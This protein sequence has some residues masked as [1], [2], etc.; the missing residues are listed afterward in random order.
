MLRDWDPDLVQ[1]LMQPDIMTIPARV[2]E[3]GI[4]RGEVTGPVFSV[5]ERFGALHMRYTERKRNIVWKQD[6]AS[7]TAVEAIEKLLASD[8][9]YIFRGGMEPGMG[10]LCNNVL[11]DRASFVDRP[12]HPK[13]LLY[14][15][16]YVD[17]ISGT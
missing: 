14:R 8:I 2:D 15:A 9:P 12:G 5:D 4:A 13:R 16:R 6:P 11:H 1:A 10:L 3:D 7:R 17:R